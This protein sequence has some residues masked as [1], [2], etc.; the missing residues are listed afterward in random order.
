VEIPL[1]VH[2]IDIPL[3]YG[4]EVIP[5]WQFLQR[6]ERSATLGERVATGA[7]EQHFRGIHLQPAPLYHR[8][9][10]SWST[11]TISTSGELNQVWAPIPG[12]PKR[13]S[14][15]QQRDPWQLTQHDALGH[16]CVDAGKELFEERRGL[17]LPLRGFT[18]T[19]NIIPNVLEQGGMERQH[20]DVPSQ[21]TPRCLQHLGRG[22][23]A[24]CS[25]VLR[26]NQV[27]LQGAQQVKIQLIDAQPSLDHGYFTIKRMPLSWLTA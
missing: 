14:P 9:W 21:N 13:I 19:M 24:D 6:R 8:A 10:C 16:D 22:D 1:S 27:W 15:D 3:A 26:H 7:E 4:W 18:Y 17:A 12:Q 25:L 11:Q 20:F 23:A 2:S 5:A